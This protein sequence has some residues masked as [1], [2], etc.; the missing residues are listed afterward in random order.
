LM[1]LLQLQRLQRHLLFSH[2]HD[3]LLF[4]V[5]AGMLGG[6]DYDVFLDFDPQAPEIA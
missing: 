5:R 2:C 3:V 1:P 6:A 4:P